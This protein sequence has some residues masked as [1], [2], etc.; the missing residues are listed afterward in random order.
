MLIG[1]LRLLARVPLSWVHA[2][3]SFVG[4]ATYLLSPRYAARLRENLLQSRLWRDERH[5]QQIL[6]QNIAQAGRAALELIPVWFL[7]RSRASALALPDE[8]GALIAKA[9]ARGKGVIFL[10][11]HLGC[12][13]MAALCVARHTP[14]TVLYRPP[15]QRI[16]Q[17]LV[18]AGRA[19]GQVELAPTNMHGVRLLFRALRRGGCVGIL[20][21][22]APSRGD[23]AWADFFGRPAYTMT[24][25][26][27]LAEATGATVI[28]TFARRLPYGR[29]YAFEAVEVTPPAAGAEGARMLNA[30][31]EDMVVRCPEQYLWAY[32][33]YKVPAGARPPGIATAPED[34]RP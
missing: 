28:M 7:P 34:V 29:G 23:G 10:T 26:G 4:W 15:K 31:V 21:D 9:L 5:F 25:V 12:P 16:L 24:L 30:L 17:P 22:Q 8:T 13:D 27:R 1:L 32:N 11:P 14:L 2:A 20:P 33:R 6:R 19:S 18:E 3:G